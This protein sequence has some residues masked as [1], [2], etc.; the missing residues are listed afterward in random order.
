MATMYTSSLKIIS[1]NHESLNQEQY[2]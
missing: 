2:L 1:I